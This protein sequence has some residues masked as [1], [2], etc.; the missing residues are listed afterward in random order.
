V[1]VVGVHLH[2]ENVRM[3][4]RVLDLEN[5]TVFPGAMVFFCS[6]GLL[7]EPP[8]DFGHDALIALLLYV[9]LAD[10]AT[11]R[12]KGEKAPAVGDIARNPAATSMVLTSATKRRFTTGTYIRHLGTPSAE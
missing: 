4:I 11:K 7:Q 10:F 9:P 8:S 3:R 5:V 2:G 12:L 1:A 6:S